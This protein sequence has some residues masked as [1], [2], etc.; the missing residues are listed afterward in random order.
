METN[1]SSFQKAANGNITVHFNRELMET[2]HSSFQQAA[3][4]NKSQ[5]IHFQK[6]ASGEKMNKSDLVSIRGQWKQIRDF[7]KWP[8]ETVNRISFE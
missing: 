8:M 7:S 4:G 3:N 1:H 6:A 5:L 2:N